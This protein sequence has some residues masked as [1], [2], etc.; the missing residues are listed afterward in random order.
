VSTLA[1]QVVSPDDGYAPEFSVE[2]DG[3]P[4]DP[5]TKNDVLNVRVVRDLENMASF[6]FTLNN[7]DDR[8][9]RFKYFEA[10]RDPLAIGARV[11]IKLGYA[12]QLVPV[13]SGQITSLRPSFPES[14]SPTIGVSG[15][16]GMQKLKRRKARDNEPKLYRNQRDWQIAQTIAARNDLAAKVDKVGPVHERV[17]QKNQDDAEFLIERA[18]RIDFECF[19]LHDPGTGRD[20]LHFQ[21]PRDGRDG[22]QAVVYRL[23]YGPGL[24]AEEQRP[25]GAGPL[26]PNLIEFT[27][28]LTLSDQV[29]KVTVRGWNPRTKK[30]IRFTASARNLPS[31]PGAEG[32]NGPGTAEK[33][34]GD[35][36]EIVVEQPV[37]SE[38][39][40]RELA[41]SLLRERAYRFNTGSGRIAGL[42]QLRPNDNLELRGL[43]RRFSGLYYVR[44]V[45]HT[46]GGSGFFT[47]FDVRRPKDGGGR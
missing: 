17:W 39:E 30:P 40:A 47:R 20:T 24:A 7:W 41:I 23:T 33:V 26:L 21:A 28:T 38:E 25:G 22:K 31:L 15:T 12:D 44:Q 19:V 32:L 1:P 5:T 4:L 35:R 3:R 6:D 29:S 2:V 27:P 45:E 36:Q 37:D 11:D 18:K 43:G 42:P 34:L 14:G 46:L 8:Q 9:L 10:A 13:I 16:D